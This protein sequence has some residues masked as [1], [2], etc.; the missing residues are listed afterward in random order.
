MK[1]PWI[2][3]HQ[4]TLNASTSGVLTFSSF[5]TALAKTGVSSSLKRTYRPTATMRMESKNGI[6]QPQT[7]KG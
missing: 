6:R 5:L 3:G 4:A 1:V 2:M 7:R